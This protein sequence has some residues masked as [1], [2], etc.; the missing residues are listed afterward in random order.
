ML[1]TAENY[2][3]DMNNRCLGIHVTKEL[4]ENFLKMLSVSYLYT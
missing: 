4:E 2:F 1:S 3:N